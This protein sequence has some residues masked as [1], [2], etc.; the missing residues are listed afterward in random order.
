MS[1]SQVAAEII[2]PGPQLFLLQGTRFMATDKGRHIAILLTVDRSLMSAE[3]VGR[4][5]TPNTLGA[6]FVIAL[7][8]PVMPV[9]MLS[10][11]C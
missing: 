8:R 7:I 1:A 4:A 2:S 6:I 9:I 3:I 11:A 10:V 5:E